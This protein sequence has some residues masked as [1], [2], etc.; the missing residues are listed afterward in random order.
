MDSNEW[1]HVVRSTSNNSSNLKL[2]LS[3]STQ[4]KIAIHSGEVL[5]AQLL[6]RIL[7]LALF[8]ILHTTKPTNP[9][10]APLAYF[11]DTQIGVTLNR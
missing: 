4:L 11:T 2:T 1:N 10:R 7:G 6:G 5:H 3:R 8:R 9:N